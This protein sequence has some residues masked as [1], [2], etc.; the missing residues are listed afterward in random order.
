M[1]PP[2][3]ATRAS[4]VPRGTSEGSS[5]LKCAIC[6]SD[7][8]SLVFEVQ[9]HFLTKEQ[10][11]LMECQ[12]CGLRATH[13]MPAPDQ[14]SRY[15]ESPAYLSHSEQPKG[16]V[17][18]VYAW[19]RNR[20]IKGKHKLLGTHMNQGRVLD[21]GCGTGEFL[22]YLNSRGYQVEGVEPSLKAREQAIATHGLR[23]LPTLD[24]L[25]NK[26]HYQAITLWHVLEHMHDLRDTMKR[27]YALLADRG[28]LIIA[29]PDRESW[30]AQHYGA[31]WAAWDVPRH[32]HHFSRKDVTRLLDEHGFSL[33]EI[34]RMPFDAY[35]VSLLSERY[36]GHGFFMAATLAVLKGIWSNLQAWAGKRPTSSSLF[37][38][39]K[40]EP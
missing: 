23:V 13:P 32:L 19:V 34:R 6:G 9:D 16:L 21:M 17:S 30:D 39:R 3:E 33:L 38:A 37:V 12:G 7:A 5:T 31:H 15:Y 22:A 28:V 27:L 36:K 8:L 4:I 24:Q 10:F 29:V 40:H 1:S 26:E 14:I 20:A 2:T 11:S 18:H 35:Y 25:P